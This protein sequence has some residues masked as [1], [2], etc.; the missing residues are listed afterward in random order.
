MDFNPNKQY[1]L[2]TGGD[3]GILSV[4][5]TRNP[6]Q[7]LAATRQHSH[8]VWGARFNTFHDQLLLSCGSD[9]RVVLTSYASL[10]SEPYGAVLEEEIDNVLDDGLVQ[11]WADHEDSV[12][13]AEWSAADPWIFGSLSY[14]GRLVIGHVPRAVK[15]RILNLV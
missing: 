7:P 15:F 13:T 9:T 6:G 3:D 1:S 10:S 2:V 4:W 8:W 11:V 12:Y 14:D 5:D